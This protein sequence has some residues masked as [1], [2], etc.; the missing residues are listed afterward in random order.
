MTEGNQILVTG[1]TGA[2]GGAVVRELL[3]KGRG[4][5][6]LTRN[7]SSPAAQALSAKGVELVTADFEDRASLERAIRGTSTV[8]AMSTFFESG[9]EAETRQGINLVTASAQAGIRHIVYT[10]VAGAERATGIPHFESKYA[11]ERAVRTLGVP[12][13]IVAPVFFMDNFRAPWLAD[14]IAD[15]R[16][17]MAMPATRR[18]QQIAVADIGRFVAHV[19]ERPNEF[20]D[21]RID[22]ASDELTGATAAR[23]LGRAS[24]RSV[25][26]AELP[27]D[28]VRRWNEDLA[29]M[30]EWFDRVGYDVDIVGLRTRY[31]EIGWHRFEAWAAEQSWAPAPVAATAG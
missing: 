6:A 10:S 11:V 2:Q 14:G 17:A 31:P 12:F 22:I 20:L 13:T 28:G 9:A 27:I 16:V 29:K 26:Y 4:V 30:F 21:A 1:A 15:G 5:R 19:I 25:E 24:G 18:L 23:V 7:P 3:A 8:F